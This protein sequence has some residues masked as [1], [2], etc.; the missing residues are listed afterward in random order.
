[1][2][3]KFSSFLSIIQIYFEKN[4]IILKMLQ[5]D[6]KLFG[7]VHFK[8]EWVEF[9]SWDLRAMS[10]VE[11]RKWKDNH[12][13]LVHVIPDKNSPLIFF[14][15]GHK[16]FSYFPDK[17]KQTGKGSQITLSHILRQKVIAEKSSACFSAKNK[18]LRNSREIKKFEI[19][20]KTIELDKEIAIDGCDFIPDLAIEFDEPADLALKWKN[21]VFIEVVEKHETNGKKIEAYEKLGHGVIEIPYSKAF[22]DLRKK[23]ISEIKK[24]EVDRLISK[25]R[26]YFKNE[27]WADLIV[28]P[29]SNEY[30]QFKAESILSRKNIQLTQN[31]DEL[32]V[33]HENLLKK[34]NQLLNLTQ[35]QDLLNKSMA[36]DLVEKKTVIDNLS[37]EILSLKTRINCWNEKNL[38]SKLLKW[39]NV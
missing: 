29:T 31:M 1:M 17:D 39:L 24:N 4:Q 8:N 21:K 22:E 33:K 6:Q 2:W 35:S 3:E 36:S 18:I 20:Y 14:N 16:T 28:D 10:D 11:Y 7:Y 25:I 27:I 19:V 9:N 30:L 12:N 13:K 34:F 23:S 15:R 5:R 38:F 26:N 37:K 32:Q